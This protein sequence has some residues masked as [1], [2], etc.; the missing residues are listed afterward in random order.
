MGGTFSHT[1]NPPSPWGWTYNLWP[2]TLKAAPFCLYLGSHTA[3]PQRETRG[4]A[5]DKEEGGATSE[6]LAPLFSFSFPCPCPSK[7]SEV[8]SPALHS[9]L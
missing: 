4:W 3:G 6:E 9:V 5:A 7:A 8:P 2:L 1:G